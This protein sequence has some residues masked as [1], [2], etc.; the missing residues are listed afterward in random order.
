MRTKTQFVDAWKKWTISYTEYLDK[1]AS[2]DGGIPYDD[3][4]LHAEADEATFKWDESRGHSDLGNYYR[5]KLLNRNG[6]PFVGFANLEGAI[7]IATSNATGCYGR[8]FAH[9]IWVAPVV[10][11]AYKRRQSLLASLP[12]RSAAVEM[13]HDSP[14]HVSLDTAPFFCWDW[15]NGGSL[16]YIIAE[17]ADDYVLQEGGLYGVMSKDEARRL[18]KWMGGGRSMSAQMY[19]TAVESWTAT[20]MKLYCFVNQSFDPCS[21]EECSAWWT[22]E[23][24]EAAAAGRD[25]ERIEW[26][27]NDVKTSDI[28]I[29]END[30]DGDGEQYNDVDDQFNVFLN[31]NAIRVQA[32]RR[33]NS[34]SNRSKEEVDAQQSIESEQVRKADGG[35]CILQ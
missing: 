29:L 24:A 30:N 14:L 26:T 31:R 35:W 20:T 21:C 33:K 4:P 34:N 3:R 27:V 19:T 7:C 22:R 9:G 8:D 2:D 13:L 6:E 28:L 18:E 10:A 11:E 5:E 32:E 17:N 23:Q 1:R 16:P 15:K 12:L 25:N